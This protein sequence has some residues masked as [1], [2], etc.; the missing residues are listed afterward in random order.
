VKAPLIKECVAN[1]ECKLQ[2]Q[3]TSGD[4]TIF[5][6]EIVDAHVDKGAFRNAYNLK[7]AR[8]IFH[9]G[10]DKFATLNPRIFKPKPRESEG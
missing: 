9:L 2:T 6:G 3:C 10:G 5:V 7:K 1:L 8:M 4:H